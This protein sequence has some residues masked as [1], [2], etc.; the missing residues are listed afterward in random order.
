MANSIY[1]S[2]IFLSSLTRSGVE[3]PRSE[4]INFGLDN[5]SFKLNRDHHDHDWVHSYLESI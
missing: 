3:L 2:K 5:G 4:F 1:L